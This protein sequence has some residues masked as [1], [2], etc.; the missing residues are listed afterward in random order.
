MGEGN[1][2]PGRDPAPASPRPMRVL[3]ADAQRLFAESLAIAMRVSAF[4]VVDEYPSTGLA[5][6]KLVVQ[7]RPD[8][9]LI[10]YWMSDMDGPAATRA[11]QAWAPGTTVLLLS[12]FRGPSQVHEALSAGAAGYLPKSLPFPQLVDAVRRASAGESPVYQR[13]LGRLAHAIDQRAEEAL[14]TQ[15]RLFA[16]TQREVQILQLLN[17]GLAAKQVAQLLSITVGTV[18]NHI[19]KILLKTGASTQAEAM[20]MGRR[21][22]LITD[23]TMLPPSSEDRPGG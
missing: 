21:A 20:A 10:D 12:W 1:R 18:K 13:H 14:A 19:H 11:I 7:E 9:A 15:K 2:G 6:A 8:V 3:V 22:R 4:E 17:Q 5:A 23:E 16:L